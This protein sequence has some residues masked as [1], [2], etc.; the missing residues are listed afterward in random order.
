MLSIGEYIKEKRNERGLSARELARRS[1]VSQPYLSQLETGKNN[2]PTADVLQKIATGLG[3]DFKEIW[4]I[5][6]KETLVDAL[7]KAMDGDTELF[8]STISVKVPSRI[9]YEMEENRKVN[10]ITKETDLFDLFY[11]LSMEKELCYKGKRLSSEDK[12]FVLQ[13]L[14]RAISQND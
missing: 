9:E 1:G 11:L 13:V 4:N 14:E 12:K 6:R 3:V 7:T 2:N 5:L 8:E 10:R